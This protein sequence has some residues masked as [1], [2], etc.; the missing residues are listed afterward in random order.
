RPP[1]DVTVLTSDVIESSTGERADIDN[2]SLDDEATYSL[3]RRGESVG[4]FQLEGG[5]MRQLLRQMQ[6]TGF[7]EIAA[8]IALYRPGPMANIPHYVA[9]KHGREE[10]AYLHPDLEPILGRSYGVLVFQEAV[11]EIAHKIAG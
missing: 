10:I 7:E 9:R 11:I 4:L 6:P 2:V 8:I 3:L 1:P 5:Q